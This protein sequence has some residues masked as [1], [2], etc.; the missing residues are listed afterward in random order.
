MKS[1]SSF[2]IAIRYLLGRAH[3]GGRYLRGAAAGIAVS[4]IPIIVTLIVADGMI[5]GIIDRYMELGTGHLQ[6]FSFNGIESLDE[7]AGE[8]RGMDGVRGVWLEQR[9]M[10]V[11]VGKKG[12]TGA[13]IRAIDPSFWEDTGSADYLKLI[14]GTV[15]IQTDRQMML[16]ESLAASIGAEI[17]DTVR[18]MTILEGD[19][20]KNIPRIIP[21]T[22]SG[23]VS[24]GYHELDALW[25]IISG[26]GGRRILSRE[27]VSSSLIVKIDNP[28]YKTE[29]MAWQLFSHLKSGFSVYTWKDLMRSQ[30]SSYESTRQTLLLIMALIVII[31]AVN[32]SS[33]T[34]MLVIERQRD[35]AVLKVTGA[36][37][38][39][40]KGIF[41][42]GSFLT[43]LCGAVIG[44]AAGLLLGNFINPII[45]SLEKFLGFFS[46]LAGGSEVKILDPGFYL[47]TIPIIIDWQAVF[48]IGFFT[49]LCSVL[50]SWLPAKRAGKLKPM[51]LLRKN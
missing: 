17:G 46:R 3:E 40:I 21:F 2:F 31:A 1:R 12:K 51:E 11:L 45:R 14:D 32:V 15:Q 9:G 38:D 42:W 37:A 29:P 4:L 25:C 27:A 7:I 44:I 13:S 41:L 36:S 39:G 48:L 24:S 5:R 49:I 30:Y 35:I 28:Y 18:L 22:V 10:G 16:G 6:V 50:A 20:G 34:S 43:G 8:I 23:I 19:N 47:E 33:A 26:E